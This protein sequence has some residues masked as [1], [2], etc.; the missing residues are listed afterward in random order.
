M[1]RTLPYSEDNVERT[2]GLPSDHEELEGTLGVP[3]DAR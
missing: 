1:D 3:R 2:I